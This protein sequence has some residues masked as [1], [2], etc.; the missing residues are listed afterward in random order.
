MKKK[1]IV[2]TESYLVNMIKRV[3][4]EISDQT[5]TKA[6][7]NA[8]DKVNDMRNLKNRAEKY[9][10]PKTGEEKPF[11]REY[12]RRVKQLDKFKQRVLKQM[13]YLDDIDYRNGRVK[14]YGSDVRFDTQGQDF[15][16][17][18]AISREEAFKIPNA[19]VA[20]ANKTGIDN[21]LEYSRKEIDDFI[22]DTPEMTPFKQGLYKD[23]RDKFNKYKEE[24]EKN[25]KDYNAYFG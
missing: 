12:D 11:R 9:Y 23:M 10:N 16:G 25:D 22:R 7:M 21:Q 5:V 18:G 14:G 6:F 19:M 24:K 4:N 1:R 20:R 15:K 3:L 13:P 8:S 2:M 17:S